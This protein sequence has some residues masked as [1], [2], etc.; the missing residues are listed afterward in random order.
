M[1]EGIS[2]DTKPPSYEDAIKRYE[3]VIAEDYDPPLT[4]EELASIKSTCLAG[5]CIFIRCYF[6]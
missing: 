4:D 5:G 6:R 2:I 1:K 3:D